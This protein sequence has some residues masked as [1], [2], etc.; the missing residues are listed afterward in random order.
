[1]LLEGT[2]IGAGEI[3]VLAALGVP[4]VPVRRRPKVAVFA[5]GTELLEVDEPLVPG[6]IRN[7]NSPC[8]RR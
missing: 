8:W 1:M 3:A 6:K 5:T 7:S 2:L 4:E